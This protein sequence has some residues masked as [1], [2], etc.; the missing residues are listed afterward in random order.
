MNSIEI[1]VNE[2]E[3]SEQGGFGGRLKGCREGQTELVFQP[4]AAQRSYLD[5]VDGLFA[6]VKYLHFLCLYLWSTVS[7]RNCELLPLI[8]AARVA[9]GF[10][11]N[12][13]FKRNAKLSF[14]M[15]PCDGCYF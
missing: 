1:E 6:A 2:E 3:G 9:P 10:P 5:R 14:S 7:P 8:D 15:T 12:L 13:A 11:V 4:E